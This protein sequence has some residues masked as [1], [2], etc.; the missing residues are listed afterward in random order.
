M[1]GDIQLDDV[2]VHAYLHF[3]GEVEE[4][5]RLGRAALQEYTTPVRE[6]LSGGDAPA[7]VEVSMLATA[8]LGEVQ[9]RNKPKWLGLLGE[10]T[11]PSWLEMRTEILCRT[12]GSAIVKRYETHENLVRGAILLLFILENRARFDLLGSEAADEATGDTTNEES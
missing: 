2:L 11:V 3:E 12:A 1:S 4:Y 8:L 6:W 10:G 5:Q 7:V 9:F